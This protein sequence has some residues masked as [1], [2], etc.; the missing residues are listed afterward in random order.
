MDHCFYLRIIAEKF[1]KWAVAEP[2]RPFEYVLEVSYRLVKMERYREVYFVHV[3][4][5]HYAC[6]ALRVTG[7]E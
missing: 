4:H 3:F 7:F 1:E 6:F 5:S 2:V